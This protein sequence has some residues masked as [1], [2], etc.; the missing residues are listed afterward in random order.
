M[1]LSKYLLFPVFLIVFV[2]NFGY[3]LVFNLLSPLLL[4]PEYG[5]MAAATSV[6]L[7]NA[8]LALTFGIFPLG[9]F[10]SAPLI[11][12]F[13][14]IHGRKNAF[15]LSLFGMTIGFLLSAWAI[16][17]QSIWFL[18]FSRLVTGIFAGNIS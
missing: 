12:E 7:K 13:A 15:Y 5:M 9:Q 16:A 1:K 14:D 18:F 8:M 11:G 6:H 10:F 3:S 17:V 2:D 4:K